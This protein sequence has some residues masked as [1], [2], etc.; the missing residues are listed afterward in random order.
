MT[1]YSPQQNFTDTHTWTKCKSL[2]SAHIET[3]HGWPMKYIIITLLCLVLCMDIKPQVRCGVLLRIIIHVKRFW[4]IYLTLVIKCICFNRRKIY[5]HVDLS[6]SRLLTSLLL[7]LIGY[8]PGSKW[9]IC[10]RGKLVM[11]IYCANIISFITWWPC[12]WWYH[13][14]KTSKLDLT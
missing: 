12:R 2:P 1:I 6:Y 5:H 11:M 13:N 4:S 10:R 9:D 8:W 14:A 7:M 3:K